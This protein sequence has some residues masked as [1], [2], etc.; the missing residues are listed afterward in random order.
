MADKRKIPFHVQVMIEERLYKPWSHRWHA[1]FQF[2]P[3]GYFRGAGRTPAE[4][5]KLAWKRFER[6]VSPGRRWWVAAM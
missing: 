3:L 2:Y 4:A 6:E 1:Q 5:L